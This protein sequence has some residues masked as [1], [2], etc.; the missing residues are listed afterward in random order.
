MIY[1]KY[2][3][4]RNAAWQ[5]LLDFN[6]T[7]LPIKPTFI[8]KACGIKIIKDSKVHLLEDGKSG[9][10]YLDKGQWY[11]VYRDS[12]SDQ[13]CR[14]TIAHELGHI[15]LGHALVNDKLYRTFDSD[16]PSIEQEAD[17]FAARLLAPACALWAMDIHEPDDISELCGISKTA[18]NARAN[19]MKVL[20]ARNK[21]LLSPTEREVY[22][23]F[24]RFIEEKKQYK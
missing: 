23:N 15:F 7:E 19:R 8:A 13:R 3:N 18:G 9:A 24:E 2:Q 22:K 10:S 16:K 6:I 21:F 14:F 11:I 20:Y 5:C 17:A 12:E 4:A 1:K